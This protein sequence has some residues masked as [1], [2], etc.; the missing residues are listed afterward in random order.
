MAILFL[1][2]LPCAVCLV[3]LVTYLLKIN[4]LTS[5]RLLSALAAVA[6]FYFFMDAHLVT[7]LEVMYGYEIPLIILA[8]GASLCLLPLAVLWLRRMSE[9]QE[10]RRDNVVAGILFAIPVVMVIMLFTIYFLMGSD[11]AEQYLLGTFY[12]GRVIL[13]STM[14]PLYTAHVF[15]GYWLYHGI[16][17]LEALA[18]LFL[19][20]RRLQ[21]HHRN[22]EW[23]ARDMYIFRLDVAMLSLVIVMMIRIAIGPVNLQEMPIISGGLSLLMSMALYMVFASAVYL[24]IIDNPAVNR[25]TLRAVQQARQNELRDNFE[26]LMREQRPFL[27]QGITIEDV[28]LMLATNRTY[29]SRML[30][31]EYGCTFPEYMTERRLEFAKQFMLEH[32]LEIQEEVAFQSGFA[33]AP[34]FNKKF[35]E[36]EGLTPREWL[37]R[38]KK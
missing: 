4:P 11:E 8:K 16:L 26:K 17:F 38:Q 19:M 13:P 14:T 1:V 22:S 31:D 20:G 6:A 35:R 30:H 2:F 9:I 29:I 28:A 18:M 34:I 10:N 3:A 25:D 27:K 37:T 33:N 23:S 36:Q 21:L 12:S 15:V 5:D 24:G 32:P 7:R